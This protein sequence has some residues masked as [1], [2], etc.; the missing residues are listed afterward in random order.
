MKNLIYLFA[1]MF[2]LV[3]VSTSCEKSETVTPD[4]PETGITTADLVGN[5][6]FV[7]LEYQGRTVYGYDAI[8]KEDVNSVTISFKNVTTTS[9]KLYTDC[10]VYLNQ[11]ETWLS[12]SLNYTLNKNEIDINNGTVKFDILN[13]SSTTLKLKLTAG[14]SNMAIGGIY[15]LNKE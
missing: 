13:A 9:L 14:N 4:V 7:S 12:E 15:T 8:F 1:V 6:D 3:L 11:G 5:W 2:S 10:S